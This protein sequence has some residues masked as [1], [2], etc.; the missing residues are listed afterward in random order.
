VLYLLTFATPL[1]YMLAPFPEVPR[2]AIQASPIWLP[3]L[4]LLV[5][6]WRRLG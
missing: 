6:F 3:L 4:I 2:I 1:G 5:H